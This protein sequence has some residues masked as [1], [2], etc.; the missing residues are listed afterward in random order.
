MDSYSFG[1]CW[2]SGLTVAV[3]P[4]RRRTASKATGELTRCAEQVERLEGGVMRE[5]KLLLA[6]ER[7]GY[8]LRRMSGG[9]AGLLDATESEQ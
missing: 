3:D 6:E 2:G 8:F 9:W 1:G 5:V 7:R 4:G